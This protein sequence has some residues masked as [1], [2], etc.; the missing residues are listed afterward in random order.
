MCLRV[1]VPFPYHLLP[2]TVPQKRSY[3]AG[4]ADIAA[5]GVE[6]VRLCH[7]VR[8]AGHSSGTDQ[9][10]QPVEI[11]IA[12]G[13][14][15]LHWA[16]QYNPCAPVIQELI[17]AHVATQAPAANAFE[18][19]RVCE[20]LQFQDA[21]GNVPLHLAA[22]YNPSPEVVK[23]LIRAHPQALANR[24]R[25]GNVPLH[26]AVQFSKSADVVR[27]L[28]QAY[29][30]AWLSALN[31]WGESPEFKARRY[32]AWRDASLRK[33]FGIQHMK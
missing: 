4:E 8:V 30:D 23:A 19:N 9:F 25:G 15:P 2:L 32:R 29:P 13:K 11:S 12:L 7:F 27:V 26:L 16:A 24:N 28:Y 33:E 31:K 14:L 21:D 20:A 10:F 6:H 22:L 5:W 18:L 1:N 17:D 3:F